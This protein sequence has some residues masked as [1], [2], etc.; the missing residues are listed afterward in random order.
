MRFDGDFYLIG[1][2]RGERFGSILKT[3][4]FY[5]VC[6]RRHREMMNLMELL[7]THILMMVVIIF[8]YAVIENLDGR[9]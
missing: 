3:I 9:S 8:V 1:A 2:D 4:P 7:D 5:Q 6:M